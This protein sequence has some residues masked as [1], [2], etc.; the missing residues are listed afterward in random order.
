VRERRDAPRAAA[1]SEAL[2]SAAAG[3]EN[4]LPRIRDCVEADVT[5]GEI[6]TTLR[7]VWGEYRA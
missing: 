5:L 7:D 6:A 4:V 2:R 3:T 1:A